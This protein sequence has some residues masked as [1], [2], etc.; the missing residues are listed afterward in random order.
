ME[1]MP[2]GHYFLGAHGFTASVLMY[3]LNARREMSAPG[4]IKDLSSVSFTFVGADKFVGI[5]PERHKSPACSVSPR[6]KSSAKSSS[7]QG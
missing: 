6:E 4:S 3:D 7:G 1:F 2:D 5:N